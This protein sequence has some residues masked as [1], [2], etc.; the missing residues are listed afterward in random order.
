MR[1]FFR[2]SG[3]ILPY[4]PSMLLAV[5]LGFLT[6]A[7]NI[8]LMGL[9]AYLIASA[10]LHPPV[11]D[12]MTAIVGVR[13]FGICRAVLRYLERYVSHDATFRVL[14]QIRVWFFA[15]LEPLAPARLLNYRSG[16]L[17]SR[18]VADVE[19]L[20]NFYLRVLAPPLVALLVLLL[21]VFF[22]VRYEVKLGILFMLFFLGAGIGVP[23]LVKGAGRNAGRRLVEVKSRLN[24]HLV[25]GIQGMTEI[26]AFG[27][28]KTLCGQAGGLSQ[29]LLA[30][31]R[32]VAGISG[33]SSALTGLLMNLAMWSVLV[34]T[35]PL[36]AAG[37]LKGID[38]AMLALAVLSSFEAILPLAVSLH[39]LDESLAAARRLFHIIEAKPAVLDS[40]PTSGE[41]PQNYD[42]QVKGLRFRYNGLGPWVLDDL[43]LRLPEGGRAALVGPSGA[44]KSTLVHLL[45]RFWDYQEGSICLGGRMLKDYTQENLRSLVGVVSQ[46]THLFN[47]TIRE[48]LLL[49]KPEASEDELMQA[50][51]RARIHSFIQSLP[52]GYDTYVGEGGFKLSGGQRQRL[53]I[54]RVLLKNAPI[55]ILDEAASGLDPLTGQA[56][57]GEIDELMEGRT[58]LIITHNLRGLERMDQILVLDRGRVVQ[59]GKEEMLLKQEGLYRQLWQISQDA[60]PASS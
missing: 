31:Q 55:L 5:M 38:L 20:K 17:L 46:R 23:L 19:T 37:K 33:L 32:R 4:W 54:A 36:V 35:I 40:A 53:A 27:Q 59:Q 50:A 12:L 30:L 57:M 8:G 48:N 60:L 1:T 15:G 9:S 52:Q 58:T 51:R 49:A 21:M 3:L 39:Y 18:I 13:F 14:G 45:L 10:A 26:I 2:L 24:A 11:L 43:D 47:A 25:D 7:S 56:L 28:V 41:K 44:G 42:L 34:L 16:D 29:E 6:V 22:L